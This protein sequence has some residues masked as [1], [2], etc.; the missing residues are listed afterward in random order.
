VARKNV[1][2]KTQ[3][4]KESQSK[5]FSKETFNKIKMMKRGNS[6]IPFFTAGNK[7]RWNC[8]YAL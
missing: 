5:E 1:A 7:T 6:I 3:K 2:A 4:H 8:L